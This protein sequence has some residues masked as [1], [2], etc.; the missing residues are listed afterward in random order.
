M[1]S[2]KARKIQPD[3]QTPKPPHCVF[4]V[5]GG[6]FDLVQ[7][8]CVL[9]RIFLR[10]TP[11][12]PAVLVLIRPPDG[13]EFVIS[14]HRTSC[15]GFA[16]GAGNSQN[17]PLLRTAIYEITNKDHLPLWMPKDPFDLGVVELVQQS[18]QSVSM[19]MNVTGEIVSLE[20]FDRL[21]MARRTRAS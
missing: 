10:M 11:Q 8:F 12:K 4:V 17:L 15:A 13:V 19:T 9:P 20:I 1:D 7:E 16:H 18:M 3:W 14:H 5:G 6:F 2:A 21:P